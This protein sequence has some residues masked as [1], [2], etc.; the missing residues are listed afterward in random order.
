MI[1]CT[2]FRDPVWKL[3]TQDYRQR[4]GAARKPDEARS[5]TYAELAEDGI[6]QILRGSF[7]YDFAHGVDRDS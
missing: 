6:Q 4:A 2:E 7:T 5:L 3:D 1:P